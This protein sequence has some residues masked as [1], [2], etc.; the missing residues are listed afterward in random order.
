MTL[1]KINKKD[2]IPIVL[3][4]I[5][6]FISIACANMLIPS[7]NAI[8]EEFEIA[9]ALIALPDAF[10][11]LISAFFALIWGYYTDRINRTKLI[12][13][14]TFSWTIGMLLTGFSIN[15]FMVIISRVLSGA[16]L[17]CVLPVG[18]SII[19]DAIPPDERSGWFGLIAILSSISNAVGQGLS[20]FL[21]P[22][23]SWRFPFLLL[24]AISIIV[25]FVL[26][27]IKLPARGATETELSELGELNLEYSYRIAKD[28]LTQ[29]IQKKTNQYLI[30][31]GF[32]SIIPGTIFVFFLTSLFNIYYFFQLPENIR[33]QTSTIFAGMVGIGYILG[34]IVISYLG[35]V[36]FRRNRKNRTRLATIC[37][38]LTIPFCLLMLFSIKTVDVSMLNITY[39]TPIPTVKIGTYLIKTIGQIFVV[40]PNYIF[41]FIFALIGSILSSG[42]VANRNAVMIDV[43]LPEHKGT[44]ASLFSL[45][46]QVGK[47]LTLL[48]SFF[49]ISILGTIF[50]M[51]VFSVF[52]WIPAGILWYL[53]SCVVEDDMGAKNQ[54]LKERKQMTL[55]DYVFELEIQLDRAI[56]KI[57]DTKYYI[58]EDKTTFFTLLNDAIEILDYCERKGEY[59]SITDVKFKAEE[60]KTNALEIKSNVQDIYNQLEKKNLT[61]YERE[62]LQKD[63]EQIKLRIGEFPQ[64]TFGII[65]TYYD[66]AYLKITEAYLMDSSQVFEILDKINSAISIYNRVKS[67][68][69][70]RIEEIG[71]RSD[72]TE[73]DK[74]ALEK[75]RELYNKT[76]SAL[77]TTVNLKKRIE[78]LIESLERYG[79]ERENLKKIA[80]LISEY[81]LNLRAVLLE[82]FQDDQETQEK[83]LDAYNTLIKVFKDFYKVFELQDLK[84]F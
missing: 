36:L 9:E 64:S 24:S 67:L 18:Y 40:Y 4:C 53:A 50:R 58:A 43:N 15:F 35:D 41:F 21:G 26:F 65:Q 82:T 60:I 14:G 49:L 42:P 84:V 59:R 17:G 77:L 31:Q 48:V 61:P 83:L 33:L 34:N 19:S 56:Q 52:L 20:S 68:L 51:M 32:F 55:I 57:H 74:K 12:I 28:D 71:R 44:A 45:S 62:H 22:I 63:L 10:F 16:G 72:L 27:F 73:E 47:G 81:N 46:E 39:P 6:L 76:K 80:K 29:I 7:Y 66:D 8:K 2:L 3:V 69:N 5:L 13:A 75:E 70:E 23:I 37:M 38:V 78:D 79:I 54:I 30:V 25:V 11:V 1:T